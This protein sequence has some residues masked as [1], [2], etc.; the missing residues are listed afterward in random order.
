[1]ATSYEIV[2]QN[3]HTPAAT[4]LLFVKSPRARNKIKHWLNEHQRQR[5]IEVGRKLLERE[6]RKF[7]VPMAR[8]DDAD[9]ARVRRR[10]W[11]G[12]GDGFD[13]GDWLWQ[14]LRAADT[15]QTRS[16]RGCFR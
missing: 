1:M 8:L 2:T 3:G 6:A 7:K 13:G 12:D 11:T 4:G 5:A 16:R 15:E 9:L 14:E 10:L